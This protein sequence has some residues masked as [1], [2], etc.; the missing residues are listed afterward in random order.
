MSELNK[1]EEMMIMAAAR[2]LM[3]GRVI[4]DPEDIARLS[5][6]EA[7]DRAMR[8][9]VSMIE[10]EENISPEEIRRQAS[11]AHLYQPEGSKRP[12]MMAD[13][14]KREFRS[15]M[16][17]KLNQIR[18][19]FPPGAEREMSKDAVFDAMNRGLEENPRASKKGRKRLRKDRKKFGPSALM[20]GPG[21]PSTIQKLVTQRRAQGMLPLILLSLLGI[22]GLGL[23]G[24]ASSGDQA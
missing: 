22:G 12:R 17:Q 10:A 14:T 3:G 6:Q 16:A 13:S 9:L 2:R 8:D 20:R 7:Q 11:L 15:L 19:E 18:N 5:S 23:A 4:G 24:A 1:A 21:Y